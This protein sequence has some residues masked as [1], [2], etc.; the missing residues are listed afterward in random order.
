LTDLF[1]EVEGKLRIERYKTIGMK[2]APWMLGLALLLIVGAFGFYGWRHY[3]QL[4]VVKASDT[5]AQ[6]LDALTKGRQDEAFRLFGEVAK[7]GPRAY[8]SLALMQ[9]GGV[10]M[11]EKKPKEAVA[12]FDRA[13]EAAPDEIIGDAARLKS[14]FAL[15]DSAPYKDME[16]RLLPLTKT[17]RPYLVEAR[18]ALAFA[19]LAAGDLAGARCDFVVISLLPNAPESAQGRA[20]AAKQLIDSGSAKSVPA[21]IR[22]AALPP[23]PAAPQAA[24]P[25][26][27]AGK[28]VAPQPPASGP[29]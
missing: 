10:R 23:S 7:S 21:V 2:A 22:A 24:S 29:Q 6:G 3:Q 18:E 17:G 13:A 19:K 11:A 15:M 27:P 16:S 28:S 14:A 5:Y 12:L 20:E 4:S 1:D 25:A 26:P 8:K 9:Q